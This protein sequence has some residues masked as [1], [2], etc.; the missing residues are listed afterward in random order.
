MEKAPCI[1]WFT[2]P[3]AQLQKF[4]LSQ[5][6]PSSNLTVTSLTFYHLFC[7]RFIICS[8]VSHGE[9][10]PFSLQSGH[11]ATNSSFSVLSK[12]TLTSQHK[13]ERD[14]DFNPPW[15]LEAQSDRKKCRNEYSSKYLYV[16]TTAL[17]TQIH[18]E[19]PSWFLSSKIIRFFSSSNCSLHWTIFLQSCRILF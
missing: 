10:L 13:S 1:P 9:C 12:L 19:S 15:A 17:E 16:F 8:L 5:S 4:F 3:G 14:G 11:W 7:C 18:S 2:S 6:F